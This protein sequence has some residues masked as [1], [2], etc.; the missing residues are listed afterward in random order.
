MFVANVKRVE[1]E[2]ERERE[3]ERTNTVSRKAA[4]IKDKQR[5]FKQFNAS[6]VIVWPWSFLVEGDETSIGPRGKLLCL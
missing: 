6:L 4:G 1:R 5:T 2:R 3:K